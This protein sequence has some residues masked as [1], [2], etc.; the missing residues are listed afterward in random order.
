M[1]R[2]LIA[3]LIGIIGIIVGSILTIIGQPYVEQKIQEQRASVLTK[4]IDKIDTSALPAELQKQITILPVRYALQHRTGGTAKNIT[5]YLNSDIP[6]TSSELRFDEKSEAYTLTQVNN[7]SI[8]VD[9]P[10]I[11]PGGIVTFDIITD[12]NNKVN[13][14]E[15]IENGK[16]LDKKSY[17]YQTNQVDYLKIIIVGLIILI[18][19]TFLVIAVIMLQRVWFGWNKMELNSEQTSNL[20]NSRIIKLIMIILIYDVVVG[21]FGPLGGFLPLP[22]VSFSELFFMFSLYLLI[23]RYKLIENVFIRIA[24]DSKDKP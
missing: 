20:I 22:R 24:T 13:F 15:L 10:A 2:E 17:D 4:E 3:S 9:L 5:I 21:S 18:W 23:T 14:Q 8:K 7:K 11:R 12:I 16:I 6:I 19:G 1:R